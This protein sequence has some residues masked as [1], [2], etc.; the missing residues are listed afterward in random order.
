MPH[1]ATTTV[2]SFFGR[3]G[4]RQGVAVRDE[5]RFDGPRYRRLL[6]QLPRS[7]FDLRKRRCS[8]SGESGVH[9]MLGWDFDELRGVP[10]ADFVHPDDVQATEDE[11]LIVIRGPDEI[12]RGFINRQRCRD[13]AYRTISWN[14]FRKDGWVCATGRDVTDREEMQYQL[15]QSATVAEAMFEA[16]AD[17]I[18]IIDR[19]LNIVESSPESEQIYGY[20]ET[21]RRGHTGLNILDDEDRPVVEAALRKTFEIDAVTTV[22]FRARRADG[23]EITLETRGRALRNP[24]GPPMRAVFIT[25]DITAAAQTQSA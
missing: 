5:R 13:G 12:R 14:S 1:A 10:F 2:P 21:G 22:S 23:H 19:D 18:V 25:R 15:S 3:V 11:F 9:D 6:L 16:A 4:H 20:P 8:H 24:D 7:S 17:S